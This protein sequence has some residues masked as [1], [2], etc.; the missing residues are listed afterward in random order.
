MTITGSD[1]TASQSP[2]EQ[3]SD[4]QEQAEYLITQIVS[5]GLNA[6]EAN[7]MRSAKAIRSAY[8]AL[9]QLAN[10]EDLTADQLGDA[11]KSV[12]KTIVAAVDKTEVERDITQRE[13]S[14]EDRNVLGRNFDQLTNFSVNEPLQQSVEVEQVAQVE[15][16]VETIAIESSRAVELESAVVNNDVTLISAQRAV[17]FTPPPVRSIQS[18]LSTPVRRGTL[19]A[20][21]V[22]F[23][24]RFA[25]PR[26]Q[27][28]S[29]R[30][31]GGIVPV[32][33]TRK[34]IQL[35]EQGI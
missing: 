15:Q 5:I 35:F 8:K 24:S 7:K 23:Q 6:T 11:F 10:S 25:S 16:I 9:E 31:L 34:L 4:E 19:P 30:Q 28:N 18:I 21:L 29:S 17:D 27:Q 13:P 12:A 20:G 22:N 32:G 2:E 3:K 14:K 26:Q 33:N 1:E